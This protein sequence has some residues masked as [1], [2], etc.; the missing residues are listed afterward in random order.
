ML[1]TVTRSYVVESYWPDQGE[2]ALKAVAARVTAGAQDAR[3]AGRL[4]EFLGGLLIPGD[5]VCFWRFA[6]E[7]PAGVEEATAR[8]GLA[9]N[10]VMECIEFVAD[11]KL[12]Q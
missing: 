6:A 12:E 7:S 9:I 5:E 11:W 8:A 1:M 10:R 3:A 4:V 2:T